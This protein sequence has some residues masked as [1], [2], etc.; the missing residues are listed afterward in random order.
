VLP[1]RIQCIQA[2]ASTNRADHHA[3]PLSP[4][5]TNFLVVGSNSCDCA[6]S[7]LL[8][9]KLWGAGKLTRNCVGENIRECAG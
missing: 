2:T 4:K 8:F 7:S 6:S 1:G 3:G 5:I 9:F